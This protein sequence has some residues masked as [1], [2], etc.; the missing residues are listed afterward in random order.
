MMPAAIPALSWS[1]PS[2]GD[3]LRAVCCS[4]FTGSAP[5]LM[6]LA[7]LSASSLLKFPVIW[8]SPVKFADWNAGLDCTTLSSTIATSSCGDVWPNEDAASLLN[9]V[10]PSLVSVMS[11]V[12]PTP[13][14]KLFFAVSTS[15]PVMTVGPS[16]SRNLL[17]LSFSATQ[18]L[19]LSSERRVVG[20]WVSA[21]IALLSHDATAARAAESSTGA[22]VVVGA[23]VSPGVVVPLGLVVVVVS[24]AFT[25]GGK[26]AS[27][28]LKRSSAVL[29]ITAS[30]LVRSFTPGR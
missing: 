15:L 14:W 6:S 30:A 1:W 25:T 7:R 28:G 21:L 16:R 5:Y 17:F 2:V 11:T 18:S 22:A 19:R 8:T 27:T 10:S 24:L 4:S 29:P 26:L 9:F 20:I 12:L 3:T 13:D 23:V